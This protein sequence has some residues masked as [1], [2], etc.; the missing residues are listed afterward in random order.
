MLK[1]NMLLEAK[2][3]SNASSSIQGFNET[4]RNGYTNI[5]TAT[6]CSAICC[7]RLKKKVIPTVVLSS[8]AKGMKKQRT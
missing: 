6:C 2:K 4:K 7:L 3:E 5:F 1:W 8:P